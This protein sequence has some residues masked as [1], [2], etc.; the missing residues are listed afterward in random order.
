MDDSKNCPELS[1]SGPFPPRLDGVESGLEGG[2]EANA[3]LEE[4]ERDDC[5]DKDGL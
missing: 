5:P 4:E 2:A 1:R 3:E